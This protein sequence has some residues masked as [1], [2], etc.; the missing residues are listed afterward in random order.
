MSIYLKF[1]E[2]CE[3]PFELGLE[4]DTC[5]ECKGKIM[6]EKWKEEKEKN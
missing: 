2:R 3:N 4:Y 6:E 5:P 1:C